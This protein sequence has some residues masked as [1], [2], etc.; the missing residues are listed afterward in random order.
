ML[1]LIKSP[2]QSR[3]TIFTVLLLLPPIYLVMKNQGLSDILRNSAPDGQLF[4]LLSRLLGMYALIILCWQIIST[5]W[6]KVD[7]HK[8]AILKPA[9]LKLKSHIIIGSSMIVLML[10]HSALF[11]TAVSTRNGQLSL[12]MLLPNFNSDYY[13][14]A[15]SFGVL[16]LLFSLIAAMAGL[17]RKHF[18][19]H[20]KFVHAL[21]FIVMV[22]VFIHAWMIG[23]DVQSP[24]LLPLFWLAVCSVSI[25]LVVRIY[26][27]YLGT[28]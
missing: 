10:L 12:Q 8:P 7:I 5:L 26:T 13:S 21:M 20:W 17:L 16:A 15:I 14:T 1:Q 6:Q 11:L 27:R 22:L 4:Y 24:S 23:S 28:S 3:M 9:I 2:L 18:N 25:A 19:G